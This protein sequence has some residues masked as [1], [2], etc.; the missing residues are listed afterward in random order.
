VT[1]SAESIMG[2][3]AF[4][5]GRPLRPADFDRPPALSEGVKLLGTVA[6]SGY[7]QAPAL[8][9]RADGQTI[10][11]TP[12]LYELVSQIDGERSYDE[13]ATLLTE[14][15]GKL[16]TADDVR[17]LTEAKLRPLG[18][19]QA[20]DGSEPSIARTN[21][22][23][24]LNLRFVVARPALTNRIA[25]LF[26][27]LFHA[28]IVLAV[29]AAFV[30]ATAW[31]GFEKGLGSAAHQALYEPA[32]LLLV[33][34]L[35]L[36]STAFHEIGHAAACRFGGAKPGGMGM[37]LYLV[38]PAFYT[39]VS[40][41]YRLGRGGRLR[42][43]LGGLYFN[44]IFGVAL[45]AVW[46]AV[47]WDALLLA[48]AAQLVIM[49]RQLVPFLRFDGYHVLADVVGVPDLFL[50]IKP[51][52]RR[53]LPGRSNARRSLLKPWARAV[54]TFWVLVTV[55]LL[56]GLLALVVLVLPR[57]VATTW[58]SLGM[59]RAALAMN[60]DAGDAAAIALGILSMVTVSL[61]V[62]GSAYLL[63]R[64]ARGATRK[65]WSATAGRPVLRTAAALTGA[66]L[67]AGITW[68]WWPGDQ[69][70]P[71]E[72]NEQLV[73]PSAIPD[74]DEVLAGFQSSQPAPAP[75]PP[76][77]TTQGQW[78]V[79]ALPQEAAE[80]LAPPT[81]PGAGP[82]PASPVAPAWP[83]PFDPPEAPGE[84][85]NQ[86]LAVNTVDGSSVF[87]SALA[88]VWV[89]DGGP[90]DQSN[91][92][93]ALASCSNCTTTAVSFHVVIVI[94][95]AQIITPSNTAVALNYL[96]VECLTQA[97]AVQAVT[98]LAA[99]PDEATL[100]SLSAIWAQLEA[101]SETFE[102][103]PLEQ[104]YAE[105]VAAQTEILAILGASADG[106][107]ETA[108]VADAAAATSTQPTTTAGDPSGETSATTTTAEG[109]TNEPTATSEPGTTTS[110]DSGST[111][112]GET[113]TTNDGSTT[114][115][116][117]TTTDGGSATDGGSTTTSE[118][119]ATDEAETT[120]P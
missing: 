98:T 3:A 16:A 114:T 97:L 49:V 86:S 67:L 61:P 92:A 74:L 37:G 48:V 91:E 42:V 57:I 105:L 36:L 50:H 104:V 35:V 8:V 9:Q 102:L 51:T 24:A 25:A 17:F 26:A 6:G 22:L 19:L 119:T 46:A 75:A 87:D 32:A 23:L 93:Y 84:G 116:E 66:V 109:T 47:R 115:S 30:A 60:W 77:P 63:A 101:Q 99:M 81:G 40:D 5:G 4:A 55:P 2:P 14:H 100:A 90:V 108:V 78:V 106:D 111:T 68:A 79:V 65:T 110:P 95:Y 12:L 94:G 1:T 43:D 103:L 21:P 89:T 11:L 112:T 73:V 27:P 69:Y 118:G 18:V 29:L 120:T 34:G 80:S 71:I 62:L 76:S 33:F 45:I 85:D 31:I 72:A 20:P 70:R 107:A 64:I 82:G 56:L 59:Q 41:A 52:L 13:L 39:D 54:V 58:D 28:P 7:R 38:W 88:L 10:Q 83:F 113:T 96:C 15:C 117:G 44:A 53:L